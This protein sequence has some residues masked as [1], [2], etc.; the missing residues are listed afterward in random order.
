MY[1]KKPKGKITKKAKMPPKMKAKQK[2]SKAKAT[3]KR[4]GRKK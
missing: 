3:T 1:G 4:K 2:V